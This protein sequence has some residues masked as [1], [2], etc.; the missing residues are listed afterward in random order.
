MLQRGSPERGASA[1]PEAAGEVPPRRATLFLS[2]AAGTLA[3]GAYT[4]AGA[5]GAVVALLPAVL[6]GRPRGRA[7]PAP[8]REVAPEAEEP[9]PG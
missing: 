1:V 9:L 3:L 7:A 5:I 6:R 8:A 2:G 4:I